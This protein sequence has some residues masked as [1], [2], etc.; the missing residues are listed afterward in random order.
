M[1]G[2]Q[3]KITR[4]VEKLKSTIHNRNIND[5]IKTTPEIRLMLELADKDIKTVII[6]VFHMVQK[7]SRDRKDTK[8]DKNYNVRVEIYTR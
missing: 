6:T 3:P 7:L 2:I 4:H 1:S 5:S 8:K